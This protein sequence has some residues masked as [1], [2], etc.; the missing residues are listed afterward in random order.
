MLDK[1]KKEATA[2][3]IEAFSETNQT[4]AESL[5]TAHER[6]LK[7]AQSVFESTIALLKDHV[8]STR[9]LLEQ[10]E[11]QAQKQPVVPG[12]NASVILR[13]DNFDHPFDL[14]FLL[15]D[16]LQGSHSHLSSYTQDL[17]IP[18]PPCGRPPPP[19]RSV[20]RGW[21]PDGRTRDIPQSLL[22]A[23]VW[24]AK[25]TTGIQVV[26]PAAP[27]ASTRS[28][29]MPTEQGRSTP[30]HTGSRLPHA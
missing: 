16:F 17:D 27:T 9:S 12:V 10:W 28:L 30:G 25:P 6:N 11:Q 15:V 21:R 19:G 7:Y 13:R 1:E 5:A 23:L 18:T 29:L 20:A 8:E 4:L 2:R 26:R 14:N 24:S 22:C 3:P